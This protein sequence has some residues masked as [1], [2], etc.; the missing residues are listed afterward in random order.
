M[1]NTTFPTTNAVIY[2]FMALGREAA[3]GDVLV[4]GL[5]LEP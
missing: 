3:A 4:V 2:L 5:V 1:R